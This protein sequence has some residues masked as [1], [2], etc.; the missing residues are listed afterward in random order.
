[1]TA[2]AAGTHTLREAEAV[3][4]VSEAGIPLGVS[5]VDLAHRP[6]GLLHRAFSVLLFDASGRLLLQ[7]RAAGK[8]RFALHWANACCGHPAPGEP[9]TVAAARRLR[10]ELGLDGI[11]LTEIGVY[12]YRAAD[13]DADRVE[14]EFDHVMV[15]SFPAGLRIAPDPQEVADLRWVAPDRLAATLAAGLAADPTA[16]A[17]GL[18]DAG[19][20]DS[21]RYAPW[22]RGVVATWRSHPDGGG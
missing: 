19:G 18:G 11:D 6:P 10:E 15:G 12:R 13:A 7:R 2:A 5:T 8:T 21:R 17:G 4:L 14:H 3:E 16:G 20:T 9:V 22:L 1:V